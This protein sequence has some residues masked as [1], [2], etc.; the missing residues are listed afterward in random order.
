MHV[1]ILSII[2]HHGMTSTPSPFLHLSPDALGEGLSKETSYLL[3]STFEGAMPSIL[4]GA[5]KPD[6]KSAEES[7]R[8]IVPILAHSLVEHMS[9]VFSIDTCAAGKHQ[10]CLGSCILTLITEVAVHIIKEY[11]LIFDRLEECRWFVNGHDTNRYASS[12]ANACDG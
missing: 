6:H 2:V 3:Y 10:T 4:K 7:R 5:I 1:W 12:Q 9:S 8:S 11:V